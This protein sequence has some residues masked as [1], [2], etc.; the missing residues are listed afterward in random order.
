M[1]WA[2]IIIGLLLALLIGNLLMLRH[3]NKHAFSEN[4]PHHKD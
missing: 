3:I 1:K 2:L 4:T